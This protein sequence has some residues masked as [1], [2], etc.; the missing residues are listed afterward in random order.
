MDGI[1]TALPGP[2]APEPPRQEEIPFAVVDGEPVT[3]LPRDLYIPPDALE[4]FLEAFEGPARPAALPD[5]SARTSTSS[6]FRSR[7]SPG[8]TWNTSS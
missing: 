8:S 3:D 6:T 1:E 4:V 2:D 7:K 5:S